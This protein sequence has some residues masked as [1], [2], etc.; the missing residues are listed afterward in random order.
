MK[1]SIALALSDLARPAVV[2]FRGELM[3]SSRRVLAPLPPPAVSYFS[4]ND[5]DRRVDQSYVTGA[6]GGGTK[7]ETG[8]KWV[9]GVNHNLYSSVKDLVQVNFRLRGAS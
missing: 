8:Y 7:R 2:T 1:S 5:L 6:I 3:V 4:R 9:G